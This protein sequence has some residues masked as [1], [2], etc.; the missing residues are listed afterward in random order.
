VTPLVVSPGPRLEWKALRPGRRR[1]ERPAPF[2]TAPTH[3]VF[4]G[5]TAIFHGLRVLGIAPGERVLVPAFN[6]AS[7]VEPIRRYGA[8][9]AF[10]KI[11]ADCSADFDDIERRIDSTTRAVVV[12][13]YFGFPE[14]LERFRELCTRRGV[15]LIEDCA[16]VLT[17]AAGAIP[18]GATGDVS[19]FSWRKFLPVG[20]GGQLVVNNRTLAADV[21]LDAP[22]AV[23]RLRAVKDAVD[24]ILESPNAFARC[25]NLLWRLP[26]IARRRPP[27]PAAEAASESAAASTPATDELDLGCPFTLVN[28]P[29][30]AFSRFVADHIDLRSIIEQRRLNYR[31]L[32]TVVG[33]LPGI[34][35]LFRELPDGVCPLAFPFFVEGRKDFHLLLRSKG[36]PASTWGG[37]IH[38]DLPLEEFPESRALYDGLIYLPVHQSLSVHEMDTMSR[39]V[40][41]SL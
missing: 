19:I 22:S 14:R 29:M 24:R 12:I 23:V 17:G 26:S 13:H 3:Y 35:P 39:A 36:I 11:D 30:S 2:D 9:T 21:R 18:L 32:L 7:L 4:S 1:G 8:K 16:H 6:C 25:A 40:R 28:L 34:V 5:R 15:Y 41:E 31:Y 27:A 33:A 10:Y 38:P 20:D 37:V